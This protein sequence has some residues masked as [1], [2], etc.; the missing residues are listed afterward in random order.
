MPDS[1]QACLEPFILVS[2]LGEMRMTP[3]LPILNFAFRRE[4]IL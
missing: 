2:S 4:N 3:I 1:E